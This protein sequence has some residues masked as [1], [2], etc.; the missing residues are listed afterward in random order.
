MFS[1]FKNA[2]L[3]IVL[4]A[5]HGMADGGKPVGTRLLGILEK[6]KT[7]GA[8]AN[9]AELMAN[10]R[11]ELDQISTMTPVNFMSADLVVVAE[12]YQVCHRYEESVRYAAAA[13]AA[14]PALE[15]ANTVLIKSLVYLNQLDAASAQLESAQRHVSPYSR[16][17]GLH[18]VIYFKAA[19]SKDWQR[20][21]PHIESHLDYLGQAARTRPEVTVRS[22]FWVDQFALACK[23]SNSDPTESQRRID[24]MWQK[25]AELNYSVRV[26]H[27]SPRL[28]DRCAVL[29]LQS[30]IEVHSNRRAMP[31][32]L[33]EWASTIATM[34]GPLKDEELATETLILGQFLHDHQ[35][36]LD[37]ARKRTAVEGLRQI[38]SNAAFRVVPSP[39]IKKLHT[40]VEQICRVLNTDSRTRDSEQSK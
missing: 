35:R 26:P 29:E 38:Q 8:T 2:L 11:A 12:S 36:D 23:R 33:S 1:Q 5:S 39:Q 6:L 37:D 16:V 13:L 24:L 7:A 15:S 22:Y 30:A 3:L 18:S 10:L 21:F 17:R 9:R 25:F 28:R 4:I 31:D 14:D 20:A 19:A 32:R 40:S 34:G 27:Q